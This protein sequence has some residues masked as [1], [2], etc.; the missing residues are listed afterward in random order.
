MYFFSNKYIQI[1]NNTKIKIRVRMDM[2]LFPF[3]LLFRCHLEIKSFLLDVSESESTW[4]S[5]VNLGW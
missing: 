3:D 1:N 4:L 2:T 5:L